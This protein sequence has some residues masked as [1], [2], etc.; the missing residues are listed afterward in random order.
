[1]EYKRTSASILADLTRLD[2]NLYELEFKTIMSNLKKTEPQE[3]H[4][5]RCGYDSS[6]ALCPALLIITI[7]TLLN[8]SLTFK[9]TFFLN[10]K[11]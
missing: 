9:V 6:E 1:M 10:C 8:P 5:Q 3:N 2:S 11:L 7:K 4:S